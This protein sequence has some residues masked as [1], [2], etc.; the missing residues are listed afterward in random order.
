MRDCLAQ[1]LRFL[2]GSA[3]GLTVDLLVF[4]AAVRA[5]AS[6]W[7]ANTLSAGCAV[8]VVYLL[9]TR[10]AFGSDR[11]SRGFVLF[12]G[13]YVVSILLFSAFIEALYIGTGWPPFVCKLLSLPPSFAANFVVSRALLRRPAAGGTVGAVPGSRVV[14][15]T[16]Q[17]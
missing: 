5:G 9:A 11:T 15:D 1:F 13:W 6:P 3:A 12:V 2:L 10:Y 8:V 7:V 4:A 14:P 17:E 16:G